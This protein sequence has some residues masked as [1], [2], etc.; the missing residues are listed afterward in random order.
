MNDS[1]VHRQSPS[2][3]PPAFNSTINPETEAA[4]EITSFSFHGKQLELCDNSKKRQNLLEGVKQAEEKY[5]QS[6]TQL[7]HEPSIEVTNKGFVNITQPLI[8][9]EVSAARSSADRAQ[10]TAVQ[11]SLLSN[12]ISD[13]LP[14]GSEKLSYVSHLKSEI[15]AIASQVT[16]IADTIP[17][18]PNKE[19]AH[20]CTKLIA[21]DAAKTKLH[22]AELSL[23]EAELD[24]SNTNAIAEKS[25]AIERAESNLDSA[26]QEVESLGVELNI[27]LPLKQL[28]PIVR[29]TMEELQL[30]E[31]IEADFS[32]I[33]PPAN[34]E[35]KN[36]SDAISKTTTQEPLSSSNSEGNLSSNHEKNDS[37]SLLVHRA[38]SHHLSKKEVESILERFGAEA[39]AIENKE[40]LLEELLEY[41]TTWREVSAEEAQE[42][43]GSKNTTDDAL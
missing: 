18:A 34:N 33:D 7:T 16:L 40:A 11:A 5:L 31:W 32:E 24:P 22:L 1:S 25:S 28:G 6:S 10:T 3:L 21:V 19:V 27:G 17:Y 9:K 23:M 13:C 4:P 37:D 8:D 26:F 36:F 42:R 29:K 41:P 2:S 30:Q 35:E 14:V 12:R 39:A 20:F 43:F 38:P 15:E